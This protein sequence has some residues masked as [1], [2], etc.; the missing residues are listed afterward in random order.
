LPT[1]IS[2]G[3]APL[4]G[5][6]TKLFSLN[7]DLDTI[8]SLVAGETE[9]E[10]LSSPHLLVRD[11]QTAMIQ[12]GASE[13]IR[14]GSTTGSGGVTTAQIEYRDTGTILTVTPRIG[15]NDMIT[16]EI[17]QEVSDSV[18]TTD[19]DIDSPTFT[20]RITETSVVI[21]SHHVIYL[22]G[23]INIKEELVIKKVPLLGDIPILGNLFKSQDYQE[24][25]TELMVLITPH[26]VNTAS[27]ADTLTS[28]FRGK[29]K[30][31]AQ[32]QKKYS[33]IQ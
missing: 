28:E 24:E 26:I 18:P 33:K 1:G 16:L 17:R 7:R 2:P 25:K 13:P 32:M 3:T 22:G 21:K 6:G 19:S 23:I 5:S 31:I 11:E 8:I 27:E 30:Q 9:L 15:E 20:T 10:L 14:T 12:V 29:L 4:T